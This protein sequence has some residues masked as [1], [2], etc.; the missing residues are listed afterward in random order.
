M[1]WW[2]VG[3]VVGGGL[4]AEGGGLVA[5][6]SGWTVGGVSDVGGG[7]VAGIGVAGV[8]MG[9]ARWRCEGQMRRV[10]S[11]GGR[12]GRQRCELLALTRSFYKELTAQ[13]RRGS[14]CAYYSDYERA[15][16]SWRR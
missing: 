9:D 11:W 4:R 5:G 6:G 15:G 3:G 2:G 16:V 1:G 14:S 8:G 7:G 10:E 12:R 13:G